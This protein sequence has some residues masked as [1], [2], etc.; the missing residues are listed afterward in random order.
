M[1]VLQLRGGETN[2]EGMRITKIGMSSSE[3]EDESNY[4]GMGVIVK[5]WKDVILEK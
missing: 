5:S 3:E 1:R 2:Y 4:E